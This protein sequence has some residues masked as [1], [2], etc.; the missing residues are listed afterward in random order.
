MSADEGLSSALDDIV[1]VAL[2]GRASDFAGYLLAHLGAAVTKVHFPDMAER[3][4]S[5]ALAYDRGST[6]QHLDPAAESGASQL[7]DLVRAADVIITDATVDSPALSREQIR[8]AN[9]DVIHAEISTFGSFGPAAGVRGG[10]LLATA[11]S[12]FLHLTGAPGQTP[13]RMGADQAAKL[14]GAEANAAIMIAL[15]HRD[16]VRVGQ[17][18][19][20][21]MRDGMIRA[22]VNAIPKYRY[23]QSVQQRTGDHWGI[24]EKPLKSLWR[25]RDGW[26]SFVRRGGA[27]GGR[28]NHSCVSWMAEHG[29]DVE[30]LASVD[31][32]AMDLGN[33]EDRARLDRLDELFEAFLEGQ[34]TEGAFHEGLRRGMT[35][36]PV[37]TLD[38]V[39]A[40]PQFVERSYWAEHVVA[41]RALRVPAFIVKD[42]AAL[43]VTAKGALV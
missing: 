18:L 19:D 27:L 21:S 7:L 42:R 29:V 9:F 31:W 13:V 39:L 2:P 32:D 17:H 22:T 23:E 33:D 37:R 28:V 34:D 43:P 25:C 12:G 6:V 16:A 30:D 1:V 41:G 24:R 15:M 3:P 36:A 14:A 26:V 8:A 40:E 10:D 5:F 4:A 38:D 35:I 20:V 11:A